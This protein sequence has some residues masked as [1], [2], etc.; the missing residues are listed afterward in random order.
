MKPIAFFVVISIFVSQTTLAQSR[1]VVKAD[2]S[3]N[4]LFHIEDMQRP[5][6]EPRPPGGMDSFQRYAYSRITYPKAAKENHIEGTVQYHFFVD[7][8]GKMVNIKI[9]KDIGGGCGEVVKKVLQDYP[10]K[11]EPAMKDGKPI[12]SSF[13]GSIIFQL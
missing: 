10:G 8:T 12:P 11:W 3:A 1:K 9:N 2:S 13:C 4:V 6:I 7:K 5:D